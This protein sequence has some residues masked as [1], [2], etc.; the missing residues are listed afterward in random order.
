MSGKRILALLSIFAGASC[1]WVV[2]G[3]ALT[4]RTANFSNQLTGSVHQLWGQPIRQVA[5]S[6]Q[7]D[8]P[9]T[10]QR[11]AILPRQNDIDVKLDLEHRKK[12]L[13][14]YATYHC[15]FNG[16]YTLE[17]TETVT[18][19]IHC[20][21][22]FPVH[23][24]TYDA[25]QLL[26]DDNPIELLPNTAEGIREII[27]LAPGQS[28]QITLNYKT[29]GLNS[30]QYVPTT[31]GHIHNL[32][33]TVET[34]FPNIDY[35]DSALSPTQSTLTENTAKIKWTAHDLLTQKDF[36]ILMPQKLNPGP[37]AS[38]I[39]F[40]APVCLLFF[41]VLTCLIN[42]KWKVNIHPM[43]Y[44]F[45]AAGFFAFHLSFAYLV[46]VLNIHLSFIISTCTSLLLVNLYLRAALGSAF[47][48]KMAATGQSIY[49]VLFSYS[50]FLQGVTGLTIMI[51]SVLTLAVV[52][53]LT[54]KTNWEDVFN[55]PKPSSPPPLPESSTV[56]I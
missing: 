35:P 30:W 13:F 17:N 4:S 47:P 43:H 33:L 36:G 50:F 3:T 18:Q 38:R 16:T 2:L 10:P 56:K 26:I 53:A 22:D 23:N 27:E 52:M 29:R 1:A 5:P 49:L 44:L 7:V 45:I 11:R 55:L 32:N 24:G 21:F 46:D 9:G 39:T 25:V 14:W 31:T 48:W 8:I 34:N 41:F 54:A 40:F 51:G 42:I 15:H 19:K 37:I 6:W 20:H 12:G 28:K